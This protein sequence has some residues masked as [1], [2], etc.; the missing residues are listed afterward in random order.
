MNVW[1]KVYDSSNA[2][3][4]LTGW[5]EACEKQARNV[6]TLRQALGREEAKLTT[7]L[8]KLRERIERYNELHT[9]QIDADRLVMAFF[10]AMREREQEGVTPDALSDQAQP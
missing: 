9:E 1:E 7:D 5:Y 4:Q 2:A 3:S 6:I 8:L 10:D